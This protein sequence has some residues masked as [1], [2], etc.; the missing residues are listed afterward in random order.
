M[1]SPPQ[2]KKEAHG[3]RTTCASAGPN[4]TQEKKNNNKQRKKTTTRR[5]K[6]EEPVFFFVL[7]FGVWFCTHAHTRARNTHT[8]QKKKVTQLAAVGAQ[9]TEQG[10]TEDGREIKN[11]RSSACRTQRGW[12]H[13]ARVAG[14]AAVRCRATRVGLL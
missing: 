10:G 11:E 6:E 12:L 14:G 5:E 1:C 7:L 9:Q 2:K 3:K 4:Q 13:T 8:L